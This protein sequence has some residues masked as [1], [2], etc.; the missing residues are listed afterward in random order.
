MDETRTER[1]ARHQQ[2]WDAALTA[3][4]GAGWQV[5]MTTIAAPVQLEGVL[6]CGERFYFRS[7]HEE[8]LLAVG[9]EDPGDGA[10]WQQE[11]GYGTRGGSEAS[12]LPA[13]QGL[14]LLLDLSA[15]HRL[16]CPHPG[17]S[18]AG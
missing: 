6:P 16:D 15:R 2:E 9:G 8:V 18:P 11:V 17:G 13:E 10:P 12:Y 5:V 1:A 3:L 4:R 14:S 7:R